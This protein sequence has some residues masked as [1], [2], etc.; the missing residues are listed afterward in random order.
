MLMATPLEITFHGPFVFRFEPDYAWAYAPKCPGHHLNILTDSDDVCLP[1]TKKKPRRK[2]RTF[3]FNDPDQ[4]PPLPGSV[5][6]LTGSYSTVQ[7]DWNPNWPH[8]DKHWH[9]VL[10]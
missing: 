5:T 2:I 10:K 1:L 8:T 3:Y 7:H 6:A 9:Y 4:T